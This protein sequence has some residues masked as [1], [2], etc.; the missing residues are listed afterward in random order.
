[1]RVEDAA[2][3]PTCAS[4]WDFQPTYAYLAQPFF[5]ILY[6]CVLFDLTITM[7]SCKLESVCQMLGDTNP[8]VSSQSLYR[9]LHPG[10]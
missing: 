8:T 6:S 2:V 4:K 5:S 3:V 10:L 1:M 7:L 9:K